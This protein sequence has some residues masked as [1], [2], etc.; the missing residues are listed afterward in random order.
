MERFHKELIFLSRVDPTLGRSI[1]KIGPCRFRPDRKRSIYEALVYAIAHQQIHGKAAKSILARFLNL[2]PK[3]AG[4][5]FPNSK[6]VAQLSPRTLRSVGFSKAKV[7]AI[8]DIAQKTEK[9]L[10]PTNKQTEN[11]S[12]NEIIDSLLPLRGVGRWT[13]E[14]ILIF[15]LG[16]MDVLPVD[17]FGIRE[18]FRIAYKKKIQPKPKALAAYGKRWAP[19]RTIASWYLWRVADGNNKFKM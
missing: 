12:N 8:R 6:T 3:R 7:K 11:M 19:Y 18:G 5:R 10:I 9:G 13:A 2:I 14:M 16:R 1:R 17:D 4:E 15:T